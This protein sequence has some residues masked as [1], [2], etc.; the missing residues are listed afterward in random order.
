MSNCEIERFSSGKLAVGP[1]DRDN[2]APVGL[3]LR[4]IVSA[5]FGLRPEALAADSRGRAEV[6]FARQ[7][8]MYL[9]HTRF[10]LPYVDVGRLFDRDRTTARHA[11]QQVEDR[12]ED[13]R[14]DSILDYLER[15]IDVWPRLSQPRRGRE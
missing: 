7:A 4:A 15:A 11:C 3:F 5:A 10:G 1:T 6:A 14:I 9:A 13:P 8:A 2:L 12:R